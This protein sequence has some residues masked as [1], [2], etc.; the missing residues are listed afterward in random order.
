MHSAGGGAMRVFRGAHPIWV[1]AIVAVVGALGVAVS[2]VP[3]VRHLDVAAITT[4]HAHAAKAMIEGSSAVTMLGNT[5]VVLALTLLAVT[6]LAVGR[7]WRAA[8]A[9]VLSVAAS[10]VVVFL[11]KALVSRPRPELNDN[12]AHASGTSF[13]SGHSAT[14][15]ALYAMLSLILLRAGRGPARTALAAA[16]IAIA[17]AVGLSRVY[18]G[19]HYP[20]DVVAGWLTGTAIVI[21]SWLVV[22]RLPRGGVQRFRAS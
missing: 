9:L 14:S 11:V 10:Q 21:S 13:P 12:L 18:L 16:G 20:I 8:L 17:I 5:Q 7:H 6:A 2:A 19:A 22:S 3:L 4:A 15:V 1:G